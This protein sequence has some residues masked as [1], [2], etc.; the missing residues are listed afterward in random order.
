MIH[1]LFKYILVY[2]GW[3]MIPT[4]STT[5]VYAL[6]LFDN[7]TVKRPSP[8][9]SSQSMCIIIYFI[10]NCFAAFRAT[11]DLHLSRIITLNRVGLTFPK[12]ILL[13][14][15]I[16]KCAYKWYL[17]CVWFIWNNSYADNM[18][19]ISAVGY[20]P[21]VTQSPGNISRHFMGV[22]R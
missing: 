20:L 3:Q 21:H 11:C 8:R 12:P 16:L 17:C 10:T 6:C 4:M 15:H 14:N 22:S 13:G 1:G 19:L 2:N 18:T 9:R 5:C 7:L